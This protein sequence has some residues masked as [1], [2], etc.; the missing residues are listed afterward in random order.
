MAPA[1]ECRSVK[2]MTSLDSL[3]LL[4]FMVDANVVLAGAALFYWSKPIAA[5]IDAWTVKIYQRFPKLKL[6]P[7]SR[8]VGTE[9]NYRAM[10]IW[11]RICGAF[12][13]ADA[14]YYLS[15]AISRIW[16]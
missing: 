12:I 13:F 3:L 14:S 15:H 16:R 1:N 6:L 10:F 2:P 9:R 11:F 4:E 8:N 5:S 7:G